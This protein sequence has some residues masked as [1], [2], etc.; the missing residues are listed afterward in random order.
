MLPTPT[1][2]STTTTTTTTNPGPCHRCAGSVVH[3]YA[4]GILA[5]WLGPGCGATP[6]TPSPPPGRPPV[7]HPT[8]PELVALD[9]P[10]RRRADL[11]CR[12]APAT[13]DDPFVYPGQPSQP[14]SVCAGSGDCGSATASFA[15]T[16]TWPTAPGSLL[17]RPDIVVDK[18]PALAPAARPYFLPPVTPLPPST[19]PFSPHPVTLADSTRVPGTRTPCPHTAVNPHHGSLR[20]EGVPGRRQGWHQHQREHQPAT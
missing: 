2:D 3:P 9:S 13:G 6:R 8:P 12:V 16:T 7:P 17:S 1:E 15:G 18:K 11:C 10:D 20:E 5:L 19:T 14:T 4:A